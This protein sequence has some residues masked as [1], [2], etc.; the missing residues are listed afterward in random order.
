MTKDTRDCFSKKR[1]TLQG[2]HIQY[3]HLSQRF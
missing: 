3:I 2:L 1:R